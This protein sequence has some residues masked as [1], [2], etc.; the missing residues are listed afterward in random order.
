MHLAP[1]ASRRV[2]QQ[3]VGRVMRL[4]RR[5]EAG[6]VVD[7]PEAAAPHTDRTI[8]L[9]SL[10]DVD[11]FQPGALVMPRPAR[12]RRR[13]RRLPKALVRE[14]P[15]V[16]PVTPDPE[17][18]AQVIRDNW[19]TVAVDRLPLDEQELWAAH[20][21]GRAQPKELEELAHPVAVDHV[22]APRLDVPTARRTGRSF[23]EVAQHLVG[24][25]GRQEGA[26]RMARGDGFVDAGGGAG[27][28][29]FGIRG[30]GITLRS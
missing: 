29:R 12:V 22:D 28:H 23:Q 1:T 16:V 11:T 8:T 30:H 17:R 18:R 24:H 4:H 3:R 6:V 25:R 19:K 7:F 15:W 9:H 20:A 21:A 5:K 27:G 26:D 13:W 14:A 2:Y 10:L